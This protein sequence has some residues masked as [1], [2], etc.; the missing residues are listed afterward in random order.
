L[1][2]WELRL[3]NL[4]KLGCFVEKKNLVFETTDP[5]IVAAQF[6]NS[7][8]KEPAWSFSPNT[9]DESQSFV[10]SVTRLYPFSL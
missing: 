6:A 7:V 5:K 4:T 2:N 1:I 8:S 10:E 3:A 9:F